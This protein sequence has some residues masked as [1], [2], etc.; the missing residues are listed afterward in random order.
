MRSFIYLRRQ[1]WEVEGSAEGRGGGTCSVS[2]VET[3][4]TAHHHLWGSPRWPVKGSAG[5]CRQDCEW[6]GGFRWESEGK[7]TAEAL[8]TEEMRVTSE[9]EAEPLNRST[10]TFICFEFQFNQEINHIGVVLSYIGLVSL[11]LP[12]PPQAHWSAVVHVVFIVGLI[13][14]LWSMCPIAYF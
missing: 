9:P 11:S 14:Y 1:K 6:D 4:N 8:G 2:R 13:D 12:T 7:R 5:V 3:T 10:E